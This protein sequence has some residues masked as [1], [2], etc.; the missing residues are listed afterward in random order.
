[1]KNILIVLLILAFAFFTFMFF[2]E[3][4]QSDVEKSEFEELQNMVEQ[5]I[6]VQE[7][8]LSVVQNSENNVEDNNE[9]E[10]IDDDFNDKMIKYASLY[11]LNND[12][13]GWVKIEDTNINYPVMQTVEDGEFYLRRNFNKEETKSG[14]PFLYAN[15]NIDAENTQEIIF[16][17]NMRNDTMFGD[18]L[19]YKDE[20]FFVENQIVTFD[21]LYKERTYQIFTA[22]SIDVAE[23]NNH[24]EFY[25]Q[26]KFGSE[27]SFESFMKE[28]TKLS[29]YD[30]KNPPVF[31][32]NILTL[33]TCDSYINTKRFVVMAKL[34]SDD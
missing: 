17:H 31:E 18:L 32:D 3:L 13:V 24:Y 26:T 27:K 2:Q 14:T 16:G 20:D 9:T 21:T 34:I 23:N 11:E 7:D 1:M 5:N 10:S 8:K 12:M 6:L 30:I 28:I 33:I 19:S 29:W 22:F 15:S 4:I 25:N